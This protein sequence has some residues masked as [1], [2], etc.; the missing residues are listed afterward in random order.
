M[1]IKIKQE[2]GITLIALIIT[3]IVL[4]LLVAVSIIAITDQSIVGHAING[5]QDYASAGK[6]ENK[7]LGDTENLME[8]AMSKLDEI[9][10]GPALTIDL[11]G[12]K[13]FDGKEYYKINLPYEM[14]IDD[15]ENWIIN[16]VSTYMKIASLVYGYK[17]GGFIPSGIKDENNTFYSSIDDIPR[18]TNNTVLTMQWEETN[19]AAGSVV[20]TNLNGGEV[21]LPGI[22]AIYNSIYR[23]F[24]NKGYASL[25]VEYL[26][27]LTP[28]ITKPG[29]I[30]D[31]FYYID[32]NE[33]IDV[34]IPKLT[35]E[36]INELSPTLDGKTIY[37]RWVRDVNVTVTLNLNGGTLT[38]SGYEDQTLIQKIQNS[39]ACDLADIRSVLN[40]SN[41][42]ITKK[43]YTYTRLYADNACTQNLSDLTEEQLLA[44]E[45]ETIYVGWSE[46]TSRTFTI[47]YE[48]ST[49]S[50]VT[51]YEEDTVDDWVSTLNVLHDQSSSWYY[52]DAERT[53]DLFV[54]NGI[55]GKY[56]FNGVTFS[57]IPSD[58]YEKF[59]IAE[60]K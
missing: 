39:E 45:G 25:V 34:D 3:T 44:L 47:H 54:Y 60:I 40:D 15:L 5:A 23:S 28:Y 43:H 10:S 13:G 1:N 41:T 31:G 24:I 53:Q 50:N 48:D 52:T 2:K 56:R 17:E 14:T 46:N 19:E 9:Q 38:N 22:D 7:T 59:I 37:V 42:S 33:N 35:Y 58:L 30:L 16:D 6:E 27:A 57:D 55:T 4:V 36:E 11:N 12:G 26:G 8:D 49:T 20:S 29:Y 21:A 51:F 18:F 32:N